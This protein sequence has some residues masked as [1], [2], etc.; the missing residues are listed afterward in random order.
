MAAQMPGS[1]QGREQTAGSRGRAGELLLFAARTNSRFM[2]LGEN[3]H[4]MHSLPL[5]LQVMDIVGFKVF[6][7]TLPDL[8]ERKH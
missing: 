8:K 2:V 1:A 5:F 7:P 4:L 3:N 6:I